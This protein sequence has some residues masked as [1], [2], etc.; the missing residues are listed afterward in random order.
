[1]FYEVPMVN[2]GDEE[3]LDRMRIRELVEYDRYCTDYGLKEE[4][5]RLWFEDGRLFTT[6]FNGPVGEYLGNPVTAPKPADG[7]GPREMHG[8]RINNT[9][10][11]LNGNRAVAELLA[12]LNFRTKL[13]WEWMDSQCWCRFHYRVEKRG[14]A[15]GLLYFEGIYEKDRMDPVFLDSDFRIPRETLMKY[16]PINWNMAVRRGEFL[17]GL[18]NAD[19][20]AGADRPETIAR[21]YEESSRWFFEYNDGDI[22]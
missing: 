5:R 1:M 18:K 13:G 20:W 3:V 6:W 2:T 19:L 22:Q 12:F 11:W 15:W 10:V 8:H 9:V 4:Q 14:G 17:G 21:L 7:E 16:R